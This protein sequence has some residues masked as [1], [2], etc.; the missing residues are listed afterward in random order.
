MKF[1][2]TNG[3]KMMSTNKEK[4]AIIFAFAAVYI[5]WG[6][7]YLAIWIGLNDIPPFLMSAIRFLVAGAILQCWC[8][9][10]GEEFP[11]SI[12]ITKNAVVGVLMLVGG[13]VSVVW[14]EQFLSSSLAAIIVTILPFWFV[15]LDKR[16]WKFYFS[17]KGILSGLILGF[18]G[19][20]LLLGFG[21]STSPILKDSNQLAGIGVI[22]FGG[23]AWTLGSLYSKYKPAN[24]S[25]LVNGAVQLLSAGIFCLLVSF[26]A[27]EWRNFSFVDINASS[28]W[29]LAYLIIM[30]SLV[31]Y[32]SYLYLLKRRSP[33][34]VST[35]VYINPVIAVLLGTLFANEPIGLLKIFALFVILGG[36]MLVNLPKYK[37]R[38]T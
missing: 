16:H 10:K 4:L 9:W 21:N 35:Y 17:N 1:V 7:T 36:V 27:G 2:F 24:A 3:K 30:G 11:D 15:L 13:T 18:L 34:Q 20:T 37:F 8:S 33:A 6:S 12:T 22:L 25:L 23:L 38:S 31:T 19:V 29:A 14:A 32:L 28:W 5:V 26:A